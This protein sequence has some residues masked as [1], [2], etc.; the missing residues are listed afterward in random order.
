MPGASP[1]K[2]AYSLREGFNF[3]LFQKAAGHFVGSHHVAA[4]PSE[5]PWFAA[6]T[7]ASAGVRSISFLQNR[8]RAQADIEK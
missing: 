2:Q 4:V 8:A 1:I 6:F 7:P 3:F 5:P